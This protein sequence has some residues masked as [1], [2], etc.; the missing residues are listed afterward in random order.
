MTY[1]TAIE[2]L[3]NFLVF[4]CNNFYE[5]EDGNYPV[6]SPPNDEEYA[7]AREALKVLKTYQ[8]K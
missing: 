5:D 7:K 2:I 1:E 3:E 6:Y 8:S 4:E